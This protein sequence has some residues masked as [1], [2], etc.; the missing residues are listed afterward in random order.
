MLAT[1][2]YGALLE[3]DD[4]PQRHIALLQKH[5]NNALRN[6][7]IPNSLCAVIESVIH[8]CQTE[9]YPYNNILRPIL[10]TKV[11]AQKFV[12]EGQCSQKQMVGKCLFFFGENNT[13]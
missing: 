1:Y 7:P 4:R 3:E 2:T 5:G 13:T 12:A 10:H 8:Y 9:Y 11:A 6:I